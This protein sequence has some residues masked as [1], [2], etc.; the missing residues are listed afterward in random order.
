M[1]E[2]YSILLMA[3]YLRELGNKERSMGMV[4]YKWMAKLL[5]VFGTMVN[6]NTQISDKIKFIYCC[7]L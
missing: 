4:S 5:K 1:V 2:V 3:K 7:Q 6:F